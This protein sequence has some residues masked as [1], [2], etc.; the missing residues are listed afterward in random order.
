MISKKKLIPGKIGEVLNA[1]LTLCLPHHR[2]IFLL[3]VRE[4]L[5]EPIH[6]KGIQLTA[7][8]VLL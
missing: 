5:D 7:A 6:V 8:L 3:I 1:K 4:T 2:D